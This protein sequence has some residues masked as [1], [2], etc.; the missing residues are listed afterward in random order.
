MRLFVF[1]FLVLRNKYEYLVNRFT[2]NDRIFGRFIARVSSK[3]DTETRLN[4]VS[5]IFTDS[6]IYMLHTNYQ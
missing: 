4:E 1:F 6:K 3:F 5:H 2:L